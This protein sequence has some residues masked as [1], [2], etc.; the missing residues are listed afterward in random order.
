MRIPSCTPAAKAQ[1]GQTSPTLRAL[2]AQDPMT[3]NARLDL[4]E[5]HVSTIAGPLFKATEHI[6]DEPDYHEGPI[7]GH[8]TGVGSD[9]HDMAERLGQIRAARNT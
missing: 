5:G 7:C 1:T 8:I 4:F 9:S 3:F 6:R 2:L